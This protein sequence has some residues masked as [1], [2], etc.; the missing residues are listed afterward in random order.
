MSV[1][2]QLFNFPQRRKYC[3]KSLYRATNSSSKKKYNSLLPLRTIYKLIFFFH[4]RLCYIRIYN[5]TINFCFIEHAAFKWKVHMCW[6]LFS[7]LADKLKH[8][9][10]IF[11]HIKETKSP[12]SVQYL[13]NPRVGERERE[14]TPVSLFDTVKRQLV[15]LTGNCFECVQQQNTFND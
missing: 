14:S 2:T 7:T 9:S 10:W 13:T 8:K 12:R 15:R 3:C 4:C 1:S 6:K 11:P 5:T